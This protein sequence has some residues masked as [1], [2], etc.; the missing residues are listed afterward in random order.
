[1]RET[2]VAVLPRH[3]AGHVLHGRAIANR[4]HEIRRRLLALADHDGI[5]IRIRMEEI[6]RDERRMVAP[7]YHG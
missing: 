5:Y 1:M 7:D 4:I 3:D 6:A 2:R